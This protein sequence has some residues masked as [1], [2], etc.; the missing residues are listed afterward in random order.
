MQYPFNSNSTFSSGNNTRYNACVGKNGYNDIETYEFGYTNSVKLLIES[1]KKD[2][3]YIDPAIYPLVFCARH[4]IEL[5]LKKAASAIESIYNQIGKAY[6]YKDLTK[7]HNLKDL[8]EYFIKLSK[9]D[10]RLSEDV[11]KIETYV[12]DY[13]DVDLTGEAFRYPYNKQ[14]V[15]H[16]DDFSCINI[17]IFEKRFHELSEIK[18]RLTFIID[19]LQ[20]EYNQKTIIGNIN[21]EMIEKISFELPKRNMWKEK[22]FDDVKRM[23]QEKHK[24]SSRKLSLVIKTIEK[25]REFSSNIGV[26]IPIPGLSVYEFSYFRTKYTEYKQNVKSQRKFLDYKN[27]IAKEISDKLPK[28][29]ISALRSLYEIGFHRIYSEEFDLVLKHFNDKESF[30]LVFFEL[31]DGGRNIEWIEKG[32][33]ICGQLQFLTE[34]KEEN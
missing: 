33:R 3:G 9:F 24:I 27:D 8:L 14:N 28:E 17:L 30:D 22:E 18:E 29:A 32:M 15:H 5:F 13:Y 25:H 23:I 1:L 34:C 12:K 11:N 20:E 16:L 2:P 21:R 31:L 26:V 7:T 19:F 10:D 4:S 6:D